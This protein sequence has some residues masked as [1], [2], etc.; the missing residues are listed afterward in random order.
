MYYTTRSKLGRLV[1]TGSQKERSEA[2]LVVALYQSPINETFIVL[3]R[4]DHWFL[5]QWKIPGGKVEEGETPSQAAIR[6][7]LEETGLHIKE[8]LPVCEISKGS[9]RRNK[10][11]THVQH[12]FV[13]S[14]DDIEVIKQTSL[15]GE[16][17]LTIELFP[18]SEIM[19][20]FND[21]KKIHGY[22]I[23]PEHEK[24]LK[25]AFDFISSH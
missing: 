16:Q 13:S 12:L 5:P 9:S 21:P 22:K 1:M 4:S 6:E 24:N 8:L 7:F 3:L 10:D 25:I 2:V 15:D 17:V 23:L 19:K 11:I 14:I 18:I 20:Y